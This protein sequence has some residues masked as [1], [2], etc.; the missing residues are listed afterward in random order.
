MKGALLPRERGVCV[1]RGNTVS[2]ALKSLSEWNRGVLGSG[3]GGLTRPR[4][5]FGAGSSRGCACVGNGLS[6]H[7]VRRWLPGSSWFFPCPIGLWSSKQVFLRP[8]PYG[9]LMQ[10]FC[11][12]SFDGTFKCR[13]RTGGSVVKPSKS[14]W[15]GLSVPR[16]KV[17]FTMETHLC[18]EPPKVL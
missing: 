9:V 15:R 18:F 3:C 11:F 8:P 4:P 12:Y 13:L 10:R 1:P 6:E 7:H 2:G 17:D 14:P 5:D 16:G